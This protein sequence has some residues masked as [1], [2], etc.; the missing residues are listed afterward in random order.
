YGAPESPLAWGPFHGELRVDV[1]YHYSFANPQDD[2]ISGSSE[3]FRHNEF[4]VT[5]LGFGGDV[6]YKGAHARLMTQFGMYSQT[7]PRN[8]PSAARG[9]WQLEDA[10]R[11]ISEAYAG[12]HINALAGLN[13]QAGIF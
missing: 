4:Q 13:I 11:Y 2:T 7:T 8:D 10:Y 3:V 1:P 12:Y 6:Y 5:Q 9:Q